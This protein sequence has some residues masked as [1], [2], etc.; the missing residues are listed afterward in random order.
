LLS[1]LFPNG[2]PAR[3]TVIREV[4]AWLAQAERLAALK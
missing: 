2:M 1:T 4:N 3:E